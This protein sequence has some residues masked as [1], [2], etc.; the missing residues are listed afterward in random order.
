MG[1]VTLPSGEKQKTKSMF[2]LVALQTKTAVGRGGGERSIC[3]NPEY[4]KY[5]GSN[6]D[7]K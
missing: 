1:D 3:L 2:K 5:I 4:E 7:W 6:L